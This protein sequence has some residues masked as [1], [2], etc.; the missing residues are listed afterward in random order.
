[1]RKMDVFSA[2]VGA[3]G[4]SAPDSPSTVARRHVVARESVEGLSDVGLSERWQVFSAID[5]AGASAG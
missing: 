3:V 1:M 2:A 4:F 5:V